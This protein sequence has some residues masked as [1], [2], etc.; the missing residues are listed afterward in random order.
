[1]ADVY[2]GVRDFTPEERV[3]F[4]DNH[5]DGFNQ[6][7]EDVA[8]HR[9]M[10]FEEA[11]SLAHGRVWTG[12]QAVDN[13]LIDEIGD[14]EHAIALAKQLAEIPEED[15]VTV[16]H[17]PKKKS[18]IQSLL[19]GEGDATT[20]ARWVVYRFIREDVAETWELLGRH[21]ELATQTLAP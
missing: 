20:V 5:W 2:S 10:S 16:T 1:M 8:E 21:P 15:G 6:W 7:L 17:Y 19:A 9:G 12:R 14:L 3:R 13:G 11:E 4:E 18:L